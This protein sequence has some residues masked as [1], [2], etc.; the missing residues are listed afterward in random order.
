MHVD[1]SLLL[2]VGGRC[3]D[4][5]VVL[6]LILPSRIHSKEKGKLVEG[7]ETPTFDPHGPI[8]AIFD[9]F[10]CFWKAG[11][12]GGTVHSTVL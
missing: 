8:A 7:L 1:Q 9:L 5:D 3:I 6:L 4:E 12:A 10:G 11:K 2:V